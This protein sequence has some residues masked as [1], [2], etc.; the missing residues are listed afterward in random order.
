VVVVAVVVAV[1]VVVVSGCGDNDDAGYLIDLDGAAV[2]VLVKESERAS[3]TARV[4]SNPIAAERRCCNTHACA[5]AN[6]A[7]SSWVHS[8]RLAGCVLYDSRSAT[9]ASSSPA[10]CRR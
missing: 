2:V 1:A 3:T 10:R 9:V 5:D 6:V 8:G 7:I 4:I